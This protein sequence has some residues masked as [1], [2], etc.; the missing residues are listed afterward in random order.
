MVKYEL[1]EQ[2][3]DMNLGM[4]LCK[5]HINCSQ[6]TITIDFLKMIKDEQLLDNDL[7]KIVNLIGRDKARDFVLRVD[8]ILCFMNEVYVPIKQELK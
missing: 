3:R 1:I 8:G 6:L 7:K 4:D 2:L 5:N